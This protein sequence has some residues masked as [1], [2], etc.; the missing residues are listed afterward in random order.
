MS[1]KIKQMVLSH[2]KQ[3]LDLRFCLI[4]GGG[5]VESGVKS[6]LESYQ[7]MVFYREL[8]IDPLY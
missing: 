5:G 6:V 8:N 2:I 3:N 4:G 1:A 7:V